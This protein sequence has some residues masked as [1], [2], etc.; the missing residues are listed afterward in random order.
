MD[1]STLRL[2]SFDH[3]PPTSTTTPNQKDPHT[4]TLP[5]PTLPLPDRLRTIYPDKT[6]KDK[7]HRARLFFASLPIDQYD[8]CGDLLL[9]GFKDIMERLKLAR[10]QKR[11]AARAMEE[12]VARREEWGRRKR[13]VLEVELGRLR[14]AGRAGVTPVGKGGRGKG[15]L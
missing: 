2:E 12:E 9:D 13:G 11:K 10:G 4:H 6:H 8:E 5:A 14:G 3:I 7:A 15:S 1:Y